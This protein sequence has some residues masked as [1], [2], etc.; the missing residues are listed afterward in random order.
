MANCTDINVTIYCQNCNGLRDQTKRVALFEKLKKLDNG[1][2]LLQETHT[3]ADLEQKWRDE[4]GSNDIFFAHGESNARGVATLIK[5]EFD[6]K[7]HKNYSDP[8]GRFLIL[9]IE[10]NGTRYTIANFYAPHRILKYNKEK[11]SRNL[12]MNC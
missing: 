3:T 2:F 11:Y 12:K 10:R 5:K 7:I 6:A 1:I 9:D 4:W 8:Q